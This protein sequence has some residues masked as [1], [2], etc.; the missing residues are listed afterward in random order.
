MF[1]LL[2][3][4]CRNFTEPSR[5]K[6][7]SDSSV[8]DALTDP[9]HHELWDFIIHWRLCPFK[10]F[11]VF[12]GVEECTRVVS[13]D[14]Q[15]LTKLQVQRP[16]LL[17]QTWR[18]LPL[19]TASPVQTMRVSRQGLVHLR[20]EIPSDTEG[21]RVPVLLNSACYVVSLWHSS[22]IPALTRR[23]SRN[24]CFVFVLTSLMSCLN[25]LLMM[26]VLS[27]KCVSV[28][29]SVSELLCNVSHKY[30]W[31]NIAHMWQTNWIICGNGTRR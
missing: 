3:L 29:H 4:V 9:T 19:R 18:H 12:L 15:L 22:N 28:N 20:W 14:L 30:L 25:F 17:S 5:C 7:E 27:D 10:V 21:F 24:C 1:L 13:C 6:L 23:F 8:H 26:L 16:C 2:L 31:P 11:I